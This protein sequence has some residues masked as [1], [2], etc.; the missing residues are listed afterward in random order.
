MGPL[1]D[2]G[3]RLLASKSSGDPHDIKFPVAVFEDLS[4]VS[5][6]W[7]LHLMAVAAFSFWGE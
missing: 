6:T 2:A 4:H 7:Q 3:R 5:E 1:L